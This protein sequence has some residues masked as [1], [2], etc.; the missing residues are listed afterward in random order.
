MMQTQPALPQNLR[1][2]ADAIV[3]NLQTNESIERPQRN[4]TGSGMGMPRSVTDGF[5]RDLQQVR[6]HITG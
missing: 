6:R 1:I 5:A 4:A 3:T 2:E